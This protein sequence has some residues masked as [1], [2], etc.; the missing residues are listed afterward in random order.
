MCFLPVLSCRYCH[1]TARTCPGRRRWA[2]I[3]CCRGAGS[4]GVPPSAQPKVAPAEVRTAM[5]AQRRRERQCVRGR[6]GAPQS[7]QSNRGPSRPCSVV[8]RLA[9]EH[10]LRRGPTARSTQASASATT[11]GTGTGTAPSYP[12]AT[13]PAVRD[14]A[15]VSALG[16]ALPQVQAA[17]D[18]H[19][20]HPGFKGGPGFVLGQRCGH[21]HGHAVVGRGFA[22]K[23]HAQVLV[24]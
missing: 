7:L 9:R 15:A 10:G 13:T 16:A 6:R 3:P 23:V 11:T 24:G 12:A 5:S 1:A 20:H 17:I 14:P 8:V 4:A 19:I 22:G 21:H 18:E 2:G